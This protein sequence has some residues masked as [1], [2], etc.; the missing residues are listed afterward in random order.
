MSHLVLSVPMRPQMRPKWPDHL[1]S[2]ERV[3]TLSLHN[4]RKMFIIHLFYADPRFEI[5][6]PI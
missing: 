5:G 6:L 3:V 2:P 1:Y 4:L